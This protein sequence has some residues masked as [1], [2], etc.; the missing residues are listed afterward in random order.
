MGSYSDLTKSV[1]AVVLFSAVLLGWCG[2][3]IHAVIEDTAQEAAKYMTDRPKN[4]W[5][6]I[7]ECDKPLWDRVRSMCES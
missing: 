5:P 6:E 4:P 7:E 1:L 3:M 2:F